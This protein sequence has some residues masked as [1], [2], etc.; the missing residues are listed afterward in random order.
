MTRQEPDSDAG[1]VLQSSLG[2]S[3]TVVLVIGGDVDIPLL[4]IAA[5]NLHQ[6]AIDI[7]GDGGFPP[8]KCTA[9]ALAHAPARS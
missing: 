5:A 7:T 9:L 8:K 3:L 2:R 4:N 6:A 1:Q